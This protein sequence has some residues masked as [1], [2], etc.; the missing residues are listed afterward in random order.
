MMSYS[1]RPTH[2]ETIDQG[3]SVWCDWAAAWEDMPKNIRNVFDLFQN[4]SVQ[5]QIQRCGVTWTW[6]KIGLILYQNS[7]R[8]SHFSKICAGKNISLANNR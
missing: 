8:R 7:S 5:S 4:L 3:F 1:F 2:L 6:M